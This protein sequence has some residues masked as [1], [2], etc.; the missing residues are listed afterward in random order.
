MAGV[1]A[2]YHIL[3][4]F[5]ESSSPKPRIVLFDA[6]QVCSGAT[7]RNGGHTKLSST[8]IKEIVEKHGW[9]K[10]REIARSQ[11]AQLR[12]MKKV[13]EKEGLDCEFLLRRSWDCFWDEEQARSMKEFL[14]IARE[15]DE[16]WMQHVQWIEGPAAEKVS[17]F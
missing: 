17:P 4:N 16:E 15:R 14:Q 9:D 5:K 3:T 7:G 6:R 13:V 11:L 8:A 1:C 2:A 12:E 10:A